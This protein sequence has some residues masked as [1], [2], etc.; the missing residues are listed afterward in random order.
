MQ[1]RDYPI[2]NFLP[3]GSL[4]PDR[5]RKYVE[6]TS[7]PTMDVSVVSNFLSDPCLVVITQP[8]SIGGR[9]T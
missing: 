8:S 9:R 7:K 2:L 5:R 4:N 1:L 3:D 6:S